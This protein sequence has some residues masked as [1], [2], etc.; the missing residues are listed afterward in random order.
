AEAPDE[1][2]NIDAGIGFVDDVDVDLDVL[3][4]GAAL[5]RIDRQPVHRGKRIRWDQRPP[6]ADDIAVVVIM[7]GFQKDQL[8]PALRCQMDRL[9]RRLKSGMHLRTGR[10]A[11]QMWPQPA[12]E[13][14][15][16][17]AYLRDLEGP[18]IPA[19]RRLR[20]KAA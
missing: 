13:A 2:P 7:R 11:R 3:T 19:T 18:D 12:V 15:R 14:E 16:Q 8:K 5:C 4:Q 6:P 20:Y 10:P 9:C 1:F 17:D